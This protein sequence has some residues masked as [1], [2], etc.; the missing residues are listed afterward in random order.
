MW[1]SG[2]HEL[3]DAELVALIMGT[4]IRGRSAG[5]LAREALTSCGG[6]CAMARASPQELAQLAGIGESQAAR[7]CAAFALGRRAAA[8]EASRSGS[9]SSAA[10][11]YARVWPRLA[12]LT[13]EVCMILALGSANQIVVETELTRGG[14]GSVEIHPR[15]VFR[16]AV[17]AAA[18]AV[19]VVHNHPSGSLEPS[20]EDLA[21][22]SRLQAAGE[23][24]G[25]PLLDHVIVAATGYRSMAEHLG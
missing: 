18:A 24:L 1:R 10:E 3:G 14:L 20:A 22:T 5:E 4:G 2:D 11:V 7:L 19:V 12:G 25:V 13:Q 15:E 23:I 21:L 6:L 17:R 8:R 9:V 16:V